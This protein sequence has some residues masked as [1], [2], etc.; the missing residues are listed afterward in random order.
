MPLKTDMT[1]AAT[2]F[3]AAHVE[4]F[5]Q[6]IINKDAVDLVLRPLP[7]AIGQEERYRAAEQGIQASSA[8]RTS[9]MVR[10]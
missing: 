6:Q 2:R 5:T 9:L 4:G 10:L 7:N 1:R 3:S 8:L